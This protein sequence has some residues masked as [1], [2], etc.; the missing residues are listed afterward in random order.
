MP[1]TSTKEMRTRSNTSTLIKHLNLDALKEFSV[2]YDALEVR[3]YESQKHGRKIAKQLKKSLTFL[4]PYFDQGRHYH[5][6]LQ[7][8][9][10]IELLYKAFEIDF[11]NI[12]NSYLLKLKDIHS[13]ILEDYYRQMEQD[14]SNFNVDTFHN[15]LNLLNDLSAIYFS[16]T[17]CSYSSKSL[18]YVRVL[19]KGKF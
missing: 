10:R 15:M 5:T 18:P 13:K 11:E 14:D 16:L 6:S 9:E 3:D 1:E 12:N 8:D 7:K 17:R 2:C 19:D 4:E